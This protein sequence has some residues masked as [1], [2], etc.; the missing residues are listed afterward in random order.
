LADDK[1]GILAFWLWANILWASP[2]HAETG[3]QKVP[4]K[5]KNILKPA[6]EVRNF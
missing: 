4:K 6:F 3:G 2:V 1:I 5:I